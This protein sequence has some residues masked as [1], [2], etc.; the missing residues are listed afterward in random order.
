MDAVSLT[1]P[2]A[3]A[4]AVVRETE[5]FGLRVLETGGF[6]L[7]PEGTDVISAVGL[8]GEVGIVRRRGLFQV[9]ELA[10]DRLF[11]FADVERAWIPA[12][13]HSHEFGD[14]LSPTDRDYGLRVDGFVSAIVP[15]FATPPTGIT[16]W[17]WWR[18][19]AGGWNRVGPPAT[20]SGEVRVVV[21][22][23]D[24]VRDR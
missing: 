10:L 8:A 5:R 1:V 2:S 7:A 15:A 24:G 11:C 23:E 14:R 4:E 21:F 13:F 18:F 19:E 3:A 12:Q 22:D 9:S 20:G 17:G 16:D 6:L